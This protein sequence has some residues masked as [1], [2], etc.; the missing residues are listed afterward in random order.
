MLR[1]IYVVFFL[2]LALYGVF[3]WTRTGS[4]KSIIL[5][6]GGFL[7]AT[8]FHGATFV[9]GIVFLGFVILQNL[10]ETMKSIFKFKINLKILILIFMIIGSGF[11]IANNV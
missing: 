6:L 10:K 11:Y 7:G 1:E 8:F 4:F 5:A 9:G 2:I 3:S